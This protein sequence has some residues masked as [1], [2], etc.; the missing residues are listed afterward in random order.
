M[1]KSI[2]LTGGAGFIGCTIADKLS[3]NADYRVHI[4]D[5]L[6]RGKKD[7]TFHRLLQRENV[8]F[9]QLDLTEPHAY[10]QIKPAYDLIYHLAAVVGVRKVMEERIVY[11]SDSGREN[12]EEVLRIVKRRAEELSIKSILVAST[13]GDTAVRAVEVLEGIRIIAV[14]HATGM[15]EPN[16]QEFV[17]E[18]RQKFESKGG[19][20]LT[21]THAFA[22]LGYLLRTQPNV[23]I[24]LAIS[25]A[26]VV[27]GLWVGL[28]AR[29]WAVVALTVGLVLTA[30]AF[31]TA[32]E[33]LVDIVSPERHP[34]AQVA[35]DV[36][37]GAVTLAAIAAL[38]VGLLLL[39]PPLWGRLFR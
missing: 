9:S 28:P 1:Q 19:I 34:L 15:R 11:F 3:E 4:V 5:D 21:T 31:N 12:T 29:D 13:S 37:A 14:S 35:K 8:E 18:N 6:S 30:E 25:G 24:H 39:G 23:R 20:V 2:L 27:V 32:L 10:S 22:G 38:V 7:D 36:S 26:V 33:A 16:F 17:E